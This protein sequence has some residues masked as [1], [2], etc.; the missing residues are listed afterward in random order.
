MP[1]GSGAEYGLNVSRWKADHPDHVLLAG[2]Y[3]TGFTA[4]RKDRWGRGRGGP[5]T[6][7]TLDELAALLA[8]QDTPVT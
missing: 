1:D 6:A 2:P 7:L 5:V 4:R 8:R 3:G